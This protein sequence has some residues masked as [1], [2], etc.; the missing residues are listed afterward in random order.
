MVSLSRCVVLPPPFSVCS[1]RV[2]LLAEFRFAAFFF[3][4]ACVPGAGDWELGTFRA[5]IAGA[6]WRSHFPF[7]FARKSKI[8]NVRGG[9]AFP[10][11]KKFEPFTILKKGEIFQS[12]GAGKTQVFSVASSFTR[13]F[14][15]IL[16]KNLNWFEIPRR[17]R[18]FCPH[19]F[20]STE[21]DTFAWSYLGLVLNYSKRTKRTIV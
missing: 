1:C 15:W 4:P 5:E 6:L 12:S 13:R 16:R 9:V 17:A 7:L 14:C 21:G 8:R 10:C 2:S 3:Y 20:A 19:L 11:L 18:R